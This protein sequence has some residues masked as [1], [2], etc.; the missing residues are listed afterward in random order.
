MLS[1]SKTKKRF[2]KTV[3]E[4]DGKFLNVPAHLENSM[5][6]LQR[7]C[8]RLKRLH[9]VLNHDVYKFRNYQVPTKKKEK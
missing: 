6:E 8:R 7:I 3:S 5:F 9:S 1:T 4:D 2:G